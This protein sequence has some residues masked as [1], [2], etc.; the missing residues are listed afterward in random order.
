VK[1]A[2]RRLEARLADKDVA[3]DDIQDAFRA[4]GKVA[5][6]LQSGDTAPLF[7]EVIKVL[8]D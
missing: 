8:A 2:V 4:V 7:R 3:G 6:S 5:D 1:D